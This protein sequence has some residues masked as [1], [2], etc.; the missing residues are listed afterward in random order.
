MLYRPVGLGE[1]S[2]TGTRII[3]EPHHSL[4]APLSTGGTQ[5]PVQL[6]LYRYKLDL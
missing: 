1:W 5:V 4:T 3:L 6:I 2:H